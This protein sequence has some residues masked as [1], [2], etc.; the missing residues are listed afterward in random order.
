M[1]TANLS[2]L[3][4]L[5]F[6]ISGC[7][8]VKVSEFSEYDYD[9]HKELNVPYD[10]AWSSA[11]DWFA[12]HNVQISKI[13]KESGLITAKYTLNTDDSY[14]DCG[15]IEIT[16]TIGTDRVDRLGTLNVTVRELPKNQS[17][18]R[19]NLFGEYAIQVVDAWDGRH[20]SYSGKCTSTGM[21]ESSIFNYIQTR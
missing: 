1:N 19:V 5:S 13:S 6:I 16:G 11:I 21:L 10:K 7:A 8:N 3:L 20:L 15:K 12:D 4:T 17:K 2:L 18:V 14:L 9:K